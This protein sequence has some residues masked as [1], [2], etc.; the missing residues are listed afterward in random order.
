MR[1]VTK[2]LPLGGSA[3]GKRLTSLMSESFILHFLYKGI[4][5]EVTCTLRVSTYTYQFLC[6]VGGNEIILEKDDEGNFRALE[7]NP[8][9]DKG[10]KPDPGLVLALMDEMV[11]IDRGEI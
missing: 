10:H 8:F 4:Q 7:T 6:S 5:Q 9:A 11:R 1:V 3:A 2:Y